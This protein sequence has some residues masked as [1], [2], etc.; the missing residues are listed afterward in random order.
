MCFNLR[1]GFDKVV[2]PEM[3]DKEEGNGIQQFSLLIGETV[4][5]CSLS[6][7]VVGG[8]E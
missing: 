1:V 4:Y 7:I 6:I 3:K 2:D 5:C 8:G